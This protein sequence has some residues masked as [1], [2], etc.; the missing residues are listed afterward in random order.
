MVRAAG[1]NAELP[2]IDA[3]TVRGYRRIVMCE[4]VRDEV[5]AS[6]GEGAQI[7]QEFLNA[8]TADRL[9][10]TPWL[11]QVLAPQFLSISLAETTTYC[12]QA[13]FQS[14]HVQTFST[15]IPA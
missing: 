1:S 15:D 6:L 9:A 4:A 8:M 13:A 5:A 2:Y 7:C 11:N 14:V 3:E 10:S 12:R